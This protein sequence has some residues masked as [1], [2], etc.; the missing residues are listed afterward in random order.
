MKSSENFILSFN[1]CLNVYS[2][3]RIVLGTGYT[4]V[5]K[6]DMVLVLMAYRL[7]AIQVHCLVKGPL[8]ILDDGF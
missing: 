1:R 6:T 8:Q 5:N 7:S 4:A 3:P 2:V